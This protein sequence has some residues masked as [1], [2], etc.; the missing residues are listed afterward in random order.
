MWIRRRR[1]LVAPDLEG[2]EAAQ[3]ILRIKREPPPGFVGRS[4]AGLDTL[5]E[6]MRRV[7]GSGPRS[8]S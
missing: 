3:R 8:A 2:K 7:T 1:E 5:E 4:A 6:L